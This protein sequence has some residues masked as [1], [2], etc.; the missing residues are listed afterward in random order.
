L[1]KRIC[2][3]NLER[4]K[5]VE[6]LREILARLSYSYRADFI[7]RFGWIEPMAEKAV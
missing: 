6:V 7:S 1:R 4:I 3:R 5:L 2:E